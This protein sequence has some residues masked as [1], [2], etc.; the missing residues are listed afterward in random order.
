MQIIFIQKIIP[1]FAFFLIILFFSGCLSNFISPAGCEFIPDELRKDQCFLAT[2]AIKN[3]EK[4]CEKIEGKWSNSNE[5]IKKNE[6]YFVLAEKNNDSYYCEK[7]DAKSSIGYTRND[8]YLNLAKRMNRS[9]LCFFLSDERQRKCISDFNLDDKTSIRNISTIEEKAIVKA[10]KGNA[11]V[12][13]KDSSEWQRLSVG[14]SLIEGD[15]IKVGINSKVI[16]LLKKNDVYTEE[17][18]DADTSYLIR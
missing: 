14:T 4:F 11:Y 7:I 18:I 3:D 10:I 9:D 8:C 13:F 2:A 12:R 6:C 17:E 15:I 5:N 1:Y 16:I